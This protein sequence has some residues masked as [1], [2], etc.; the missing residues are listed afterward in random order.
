MALNALATCNINGDGGQLRAAKPWW[1]PVNQAIAISCLHIHKHNEWQSWTKSST[2]TCP[3]CYGAFTQEKNTY[4]EHL[5]VCHIRGN[6]KSEIFLAVTVTQRLQL[7]VFSEW[8]N[9][10]KI[11]KNFM[12]SNAIWPTVSYISAYVLSCWKFSKNTRLIEIH[13]WCIQ[14]VA[15]TSDHSPKI[16]HSCIIVLP[17]PRAEVLVEQQGAEYKFFLAC[18]GCR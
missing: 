10:V 14:S 11:S 9:H 13:N 2:K 8:R 17:L 3:E 1:W 5:S 7:Y 16:W 15:W 6:S 18:H 4:P 12:E